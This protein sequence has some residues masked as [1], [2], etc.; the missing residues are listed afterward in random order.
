MTNYS[1]FINSM[2]NYV[3]TEFKDLNQKE[4]ASLTYDHVAQ[5]TT[6]Q[7]D[8]K[9][10][11]LPYEQYK[12]DYKEDQWISRKIKAIPKALSSGIVKS[13]GHV[14][15]A[16]FLAILGDTKGSKA[17]IFSSARDLE[18]SIGWLFTL[19]DDT[20]GSYLVNDAK[21]MKD[22]YMKNTEGIDP[23]NPLLL[24]TIRIVHQEFHSVLTSTLALVNWIP[25]DK[26][27]GLILDASYTYFGANAGGIEIK[28]SSD[29]ITDVVIERI[30]G[31]PDI[32]GNFRPGDFFSNEA[33]I[34]LNI[35][36]KNITTHNYRLPEIKMSCKIK[37]GKDGFYI[38]NR[39][40][41]S[42]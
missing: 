15:A 37:P 31:K 3:R 38:D 39:Q 24:K 35:I 6:L 22:C 9:L 19:F 5:A 33:E 32:E 4:A 1:V 23:E 30:F 20:K 34:S 42:S 7:F 14:L 36:P 11:S 16:T 13:I 25:K 27:S 29:K 8:N 21:F 10:L 12:K 26:E 2:N 18:E 28:T 41:I 17:Y 40:R